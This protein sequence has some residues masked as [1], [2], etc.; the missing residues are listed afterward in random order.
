[1][2]TLCL[3]ICTTG[4]AAQSLCDGGRGRSSCVAVKSMGAYHTLECQGQSGYCSLQ[5]C[6]QHALLLAPGYTAGL[7][8]PPAGGHN[9]S[10]QSMMK[11]SLTPTQATR[12]L[13]FCFSPTQWATRPKTFSRVLHIY[14]TMIT[15][16][17]YCPSICCP[18]PPKC[19]QIQ[20]SQT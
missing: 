18:C 13:F 12:L 6:V 20:T 14:V 11:P 16:P 19:K 2:Q 8:L 10:R 5:S 4:T 17:D 15:S 7:Q 3:F 1:M 9:P